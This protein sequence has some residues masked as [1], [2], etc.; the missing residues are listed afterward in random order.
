MA[1]ALWPKVL[2]ALRSPGVTGMDE[3]G[4]LM[5]AAQGAQSV[6]EFEKLA[7]ELAAERPRG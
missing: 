1:K 3:A 7:D 5:V 6:E 4:I 2:A